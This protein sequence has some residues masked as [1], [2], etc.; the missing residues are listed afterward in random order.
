MTYCADNTA[1]DIDPLP[2]GRVLAA[3]M[4][5]CLG[6]MDVRGEPIW[7]IPSPILDFLR[8][9]DVMQVSVDG[10]VV[11]F[12]DRDWAGA[13]LRFDLRSLTLSPAPPNDGATVPPNREG[14]TI[15]GW[16]DGTRPTLAG[17]ALSLYAHDIGRS[18]AIASDAKR[19]FL[20]SSFGLKA[21]DDAGAQKWRR[22]TPGE[23]WAVN[24]SR[25]GRVVVTAESDGTIRWRRADDG[26]ELL[27]LHVLPNRTD[28]VLWTPEGFYEATPGAEDVLKWV[29]NH[30]PDSAAT[31]LP[32]SAIPRLHRPDALPLVLD[33]GETA[34]ALGVADVA[35]ARFAVQKATGSAKPPGGVLHVLAI[36]VDRFGDK[37]GGLHL[38][39]AAEDAH[40]VAI[41]LIESQK[42]A[43]GRPGLYADVTEDYLPNDQASRAAILDALDA[44]AQ[45]MQKNPDKDVAVILV[46]SHGEM[47]DRQFYLIPYDFDAG[48]LNKATGSAL[49]ASDFAKKISAIAEHGRV[50]LLLDACHAGA[51]GAGGWATDPDAKALQDAMDLENVTVLSSSRKNE[52]S[53]ELPAWKHGA[54]TQSFL[55]ALGGAADPEGHGVIRLSGLTDAMDAEIQS[56]TR[57]MKPQHLGLHVN[58]GGDLFVANH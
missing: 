5:S 23:V 37:A 34:R 17:V 26:R 43:P 49:S 30:G 13:M 10:K 12:G 2:G 44:M 35:A 15:N 31:T 56:L 11:D 14:L 41:A 1:A 54:F 38:A 50:L 57:G 8:Q 52:E 3:S 42:S 28:W 29:T 39:Y 16:R 27:A 25:D 6:L 32:V 46:S 33:E 51:V 45:A 48:S 7:T 36:G 4:A 40:D 21:F 22:D 9:R 20:G 53:Q 18:L 55:D 24:A 58:F 47:I 19:F